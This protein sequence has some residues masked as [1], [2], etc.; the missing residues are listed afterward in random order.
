MEPEDKKRMAQRILGEYEE[1]YREMLAFI[2]RYPDLQETPQSHTPTLRYKDTP[3]LLDEP[4]RC[5][6]SM[7]G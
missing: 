2:E 3:N 4:L 6:H 5:F 1:A 7:N